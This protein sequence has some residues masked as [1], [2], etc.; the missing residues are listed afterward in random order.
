MGLR[1]RKSIN[2]GGGFRIN[3]SKSGIG[4][5]WGVKGFRRT[6][7][8][9]G[10]TR[11]TYSI[12]GTGI[13]YVDESGRGS[14]KG[15]KN[16]N[17]SSDEHSLLQNIESA[18]IQQFKT[19]E[20]AHITDAIE[21]TLRWNHWS[22][23]LLW[24]TVLAA[25]QIGFI[26]LPILGLLLKTIAHKT[27]VVELEYSLDDEKTDQHKKRIE[28]L[29]VLTDCEKIWQVIQ[30]GAVLKAKVNA[31][32]GRNVKRVPCRIENRTPFYLN[33]NVETIHIKLKNEALI[34][35]P[36]QVLIVRNNK[37]GTIDYQEI[38]MRVGQVR[39]IETEKVPRDA[40]VV[41]STWQYV[42][43]NGTP[44]RRYKNNKQLPVCLYGVV[45]MTTRSGLNVEM[46]FSNVEKTHAFGSVIQ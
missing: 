15:T 28:A 42:N 32:A 23:M 29:K 17:S 12:P 7:T 45:A 2:L 8:A 20:T 40:Q 19:A 21:K 22:N 41:G 11:R 46:Q 34:F 18:D 33:T 44:D 38:A 27:G 10:R 4:Y 3:L 24:C 9:T 14:R 37:V 13:S 6:R 36:D 35:L 25:V 39:F 30:E 31:G 5:S 16:S 26:V 1:F 43:Q